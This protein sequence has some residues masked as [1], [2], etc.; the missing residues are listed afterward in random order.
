MKELDAC[1]AWLASFHACFLGEKPNGLWKVGTYWHLAT[2][3][4]ELAVTAKRDADLAARA[5]EIDRALNAARFRTFVHGDAKPANFCFGGDRVAAV[6][7]QY[8]GGG[9]GVKDVAYLLHGEPNARRA[10]DTYF[11]LLRERLPSDVDGAALEEEWR[12]LYPVAVT[13]FDRFLSGWR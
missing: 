9:V 3:Q 7:F 4:E 6:D 13:D 10:L 8:V 11:R 5:P 12:A 2:R 1:L